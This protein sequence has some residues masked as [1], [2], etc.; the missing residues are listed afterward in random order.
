MAKNSSIEWT[1]H[2][3][4]PW[5]GCT[6]VSPGC[7]HCYAEAW[8]K[9]VGKDIWGPNAGRLFFGDH[10]WREPLGW[11]EEAR[12]TRTRMRVFC[13]SMADVFEDRKELEAQR[14]RLWDLV[15][16]T[17]WLDWL[18]LTKR[19][20]NIKAMA[21]W[22][23]VWPENVW[24][25]VTVE[26]QTWASHRIHYLLTIPAKT[27]FL[28]CEPLLGP[29]DLTAWTTKKPTYLKY[30]IDWVI[31]GGESGAGARPLNP[32]WVRVLCDQ[33]REASIPFHF[34]QWGHWQ[35]VDG[36]GKPDGKWI[37]LPAADGNEIY[38]VAKG[39]KAAGRELDGRKWDG[40]PVGARA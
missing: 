6:K 37:T 27:R 35:P 39:K 36:D 23:S 32:E 40:V 33:C 31:T 29:L 2:T 11:N 17:P 13:A 22:K 26:N 12:R 10:H 14:L 21:P 34:K 4:N 25:G 28:S 20:Q 9:R 24:M 1:H 3:F 5:W 18:L 19:P 8:S 38:M 16:K 30:T 7:D 15:E